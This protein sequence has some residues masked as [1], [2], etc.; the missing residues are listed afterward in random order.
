MS[1]FMRKGITK[2]WYVTGTVT[3]AAPTAVQVLTGI[4]LTEGIGEMNGFT[5]S[6]NPIQTPNLNTKF[7]S[8]IPGEDSTEDSSLV[9]YEDKVS[10]T[11]RDGLD[12]D[13]TGYI[14]IFATGIAGA[15]PAAGDKCEVWPVTIS[16]N[17]RKYTAGNEAAMF[18]VKFATTSE[19]NTADTALA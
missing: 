14:V 6:N 4:D 19:P 10:A 5:Y 1:N 16:S 3:K 8:Q 9:F 12:K 17:A 11:L 7:V 13:D 15:T 18:E 2:V